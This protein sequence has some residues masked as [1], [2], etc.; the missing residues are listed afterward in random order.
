MFRDRILGLASIPV[1]K[2]RGFSSGN[3]KTYEDFDRQHLEES[4]ENHGYVS[5]VLVRKLDDGTYEII[6]GHHRVE[7]I[8][9]RDP[10]TQLKAVVLDVA[11]VAEG[12]RILLA[13]KHQSDWDMSKLEAFASEA[14]ASGASVADLMADTGLTGK[15][16]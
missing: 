12:R 16:L 9:A 7:Q 11:S 8:V 5:P 15:E 4:L 14:M 2:L 1:T 10:D 13:L 3:P 6:D